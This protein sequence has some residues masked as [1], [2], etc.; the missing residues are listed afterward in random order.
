M[1]YRRPGNV[2]KSKGYCVKTTCW[3]QQL[4]TIVAVGRMGLTVTFNHYHPQF[5]VNNRVRRSQP[6]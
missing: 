4:S 5:T 1:S 6:A 3:K 2:I